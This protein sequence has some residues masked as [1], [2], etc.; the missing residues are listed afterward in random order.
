MN[1]LGCS[2]TWLLGVMDTVT[3]KIL[4][5][6]FSCSWSGR[7]IKY[8]VQGTE[9][10]LILMVRKDRQLDGVGCVKA[11]EKPRETLGVQR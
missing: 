9:I 1:L 10:S 4:T 7:R 5:W 8:K 11:M 6:P 3:D 2:L